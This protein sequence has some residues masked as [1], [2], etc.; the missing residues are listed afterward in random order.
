MGGVEVAVSDYRFLDSVNDD[1]R[2]H[3]QKQCLF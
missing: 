2:G 1:I 3:I